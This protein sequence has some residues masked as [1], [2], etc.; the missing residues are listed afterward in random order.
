[1]LVRASLVKSRM[2]FEIKVGPSCKVVE[3][4]IVA[5]VIIFSITLGSTLGSTKW[6]HVQSKVVL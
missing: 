5:I 2:H 6:V 3:N 4:T 1:V